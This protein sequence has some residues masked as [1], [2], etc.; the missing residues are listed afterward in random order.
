[1]GDEAV[2][3]FTRVLGAAA[4]NIAEAAVALFYAELGPG[5]G[6]EGST[7]LERAHVSEVATLAFTANPPLY[8]P[9]AMPS[10]LT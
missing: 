4:T 10:P 2:L 8:S 1:M 9:P 7:E 6:R 3:A 5:T